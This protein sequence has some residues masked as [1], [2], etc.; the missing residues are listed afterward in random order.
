MR[1]KRARAILTRGFNARHEHVDHAISTAIVGRRPGWSRQVE[2][3]HRP[4]EREIIGPS[5]WEVTI[6]F[7]PPCF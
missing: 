6:G 4:P 7:A 1:A 2:W 5:F 3:E